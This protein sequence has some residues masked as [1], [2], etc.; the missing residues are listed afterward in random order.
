MSDR[1]IISVDLEIKFDV[2]SSAGEGFLLLIDNS[3]HHPSQ[4]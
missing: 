4:G 3:S 1:V 2:P